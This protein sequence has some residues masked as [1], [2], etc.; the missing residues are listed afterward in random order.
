MHKGDFVPWI[1]CFHDH[2][3]W[4][5]LRDL[6]NLSRLDTIIWKDIIAGLT[7]FRS[8]SKSII[9]DGRSTSFWFDN[10][11]GGGA[12]FQLFPAFFS[13][14]TRPNIS[15]ADAL[16]TPELLLHLRPRMSTMATHELANIQALVCHLVYTQRRKADAPCP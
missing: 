15:V 2:Y 7:H 16:A 6:G 12:L 11:I 9:G 5:A 3:G 14:A 13:H 1:D 8:V 4:S 10:W